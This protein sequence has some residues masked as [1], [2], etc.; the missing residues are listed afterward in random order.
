[1][2]GQILAQTSFEPAPNQVGYRISLNIQSHFAGLSK[3]QR[4][5]KHT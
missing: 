2:T 4:R 5:R 1:M 3:I